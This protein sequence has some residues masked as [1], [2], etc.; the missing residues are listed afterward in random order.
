MGLGPNTSQPL[1]SDAPALFDIWVQGQVSY[2]K[3]DLADDKES[4]YA[5]V[6][7]AGADYL[8]SPGFLVGLMAEVDWMNVE[9]DGATGGDQDG[10]GWMVGPYASARLTPNLFLDARA[11]WGRSDNNIDPLGAYIDS[12][13]TERALASIALTG[14][15]G[16]GALTFRP[17]AEALWYREEQESYTNAIGI[18][19]DQQS[20]SLG[21]AIFGPEVSYR[22][23]LGENS[24]LEPYVGIKGIWDFASEAL[25]T[26]AGEPVAGDELRARLELGLSYRSESGFM[27][28][29]SGAYDGVGTDTYQAYQGQVQVTVPLQQ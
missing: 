15:W 26:A 10:R 2:F 25:T 12:Y 16:F 18:E 6:I 9:V 1:E 22:H 17:G 24:V 11:M 23:T 13:E 21:R 8:L 3:R 19:I 28:R 5:Q 27:L 20:V 7:Y 14:E 4:G 29:G